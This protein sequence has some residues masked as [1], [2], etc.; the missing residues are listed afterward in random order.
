M[1]DADVDPATSRVLSDCS[2]ICANPLTQHCSQKMVLFTFVYA[3]HCVVVVAFLW[4]V[5]VF[6][7]VIVA[8]KCKSDS[9]DD[10]MSWV[11]MLALY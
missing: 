4:F 10:F 5:L 2:T 9:S 1:E 3:I 7:L 8:P 6:L 11:I